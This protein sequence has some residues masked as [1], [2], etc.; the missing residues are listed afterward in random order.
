MSNSA[1]AQIND[2]RGR[3]A[4]NIQELTVYLGQI[5]NAQAIAQAAAFEPRPSD[6]IIA[7]Y[8]KCGTTWM[9]QIVH[10]IRTGGSMNFNDI[11]EVVPWFEIVHF[12]NIDINAPQEAEPR[13]FKTHVGWADA[14]KGARYIVVMRNPKDALLSFYHFLRGWIFVPDS[15]SVEQFA[16]DLYCK[17]GPFGRYWDHVRSWW[18]QRDQDNYFFV[19]FDEMKSDLAGVVRAISGFLHIELDDQTVANVVKQ[20]SFGFMQE[21]KS[22]FDDYPLRVAIEKAVGLPQGNQPPK[23]RAGKVGGYKGE[24]PDSVIEAMDAL[25]KQEMEHKLGIRSYQ[26]FCDRIADHHRG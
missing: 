24:M 16:F 8:P 7:T 11:T 15:I 2:L 14:P 20:S 1:N 6:V 26:E 19:T 23:V 10:G 13:A 21:H 12:M 22:K 4:E 18:E 3:R 25:W 17:G 5:F 9:Q